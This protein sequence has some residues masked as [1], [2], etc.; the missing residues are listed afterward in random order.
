MAAPVYNFDLNAVSKNL[1]DLTGST[2]EGN[3][4][5][6]MAVAGGRASYMAPMS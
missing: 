1:Y 3:L 2:W 4:V 5:G 6:L